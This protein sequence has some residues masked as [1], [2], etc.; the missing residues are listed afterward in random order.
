MKQLIYL[1]LEAFD[2][3]LGVLVI[4]SLLISAALGAYMLVLLFKFI[5]SLF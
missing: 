2:V 5:A 4:V 1:I 3:L